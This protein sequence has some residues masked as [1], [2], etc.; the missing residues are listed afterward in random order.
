MVNTSSYFALKNSANSYLNHIFENPNGLANPLSQEVLQAL[1]PRAG[2]L[3]VWVFPV[4]PRPALRPLVFR[5]PSSH[6]SYAGISW[7]PGHCGCDQNGLLIQAL[8]IPAGP[9]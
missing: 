6:S 9:F 4:L 2:W 7:L 3:F 5:G 8:L 1:V